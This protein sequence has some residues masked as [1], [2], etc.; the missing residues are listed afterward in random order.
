MK[1]FVVYE[2]NGKILRAGSCLDSDISLQPKDISESVIE[3]TCNLE[4]DYVLSGVITQRPTQ[5]TLL[6][7]TTLT[8]NG[9][10]VIHITSAPDGIFTAT[11]VVTGEMVSGSISGSD[12]FST[13]VKGTI[14]IKIEAFPYLDFEATV[15]VI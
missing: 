15:E 11:N 13:T 5:A 2:T 1:N 9:I 12:T 3:S 4:T 14:K 8:A 10:D 6:D 7:K